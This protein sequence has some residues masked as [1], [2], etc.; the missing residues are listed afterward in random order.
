MAINSP[1][2]LTKDFEVTS[3]DVD[4]F[5]RLSPS[6]LLNILIQTAGFSA[7]SLGF[8]FNNLTEKDLFWVLSR[9]TIEI[10]QTAKWQENLSVETWPKDVNGLLYLRDFI[11][12]N[13]DQQIVAKASSAWLAIQ[14]SSRRP[15]IIPDLEKPFAELRNYHA[16]SAIP[17]K[18][19]EFDGKILSERIVTFTDIDLNKHLTSVRYIDWVMDAIDIEFH[20][21]NYPKALHINYIKETA[22]GESLEIKFVEIGKKL[23]F[24][25]K[26]LTNQKTSFRVKMEF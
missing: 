2:I 23:M 14:L 7:D 24:E 12:K 26:N 21:E 9:M 1:F 3:A 6:A 13:S 20:Q 19:E 16:L 4:M 18:I 22:P 5:G 8:G 10:Y 25:G 17:E 11:V 15:K